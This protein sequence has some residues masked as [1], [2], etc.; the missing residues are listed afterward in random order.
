MLF[1]V[2]NWRL[3]H[4]KKEAPFWYFGNLAGL[5]FNSGSAKALFD[6]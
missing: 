6:G 2:I 4:S 3:C 5:D 1:S